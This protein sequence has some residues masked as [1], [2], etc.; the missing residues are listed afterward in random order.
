ML[1]IKL[2]YEEPVED[3]PMGRATRGWRTGMTE[4]EALAAGC[5]VWVLNA[6]RVMEQDEVEIVSPDLTVLA[7][8][9]IT[10]VAKYGDR[11]A[12]QGTLLRGDPRVGKRSVHP[13]PS[14]NAIAYY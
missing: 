11:R 8:A 5:G 2:G 7:V 10:G 13:H 4:D 1:Q 12:V 9:T 3:D 6:D 14:Q